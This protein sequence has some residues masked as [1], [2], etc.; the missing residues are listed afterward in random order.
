M[1]EKD[2]ILIVDDDDGMRRSL[3]LVLTKKGY[4]VETAE[5]GRE[6][7]G[8]AQ[9]RFFNAVLLDI[10]M[11]DVA[12]IDLLAPL[13]GMHPDIVTIMITGYASLETAMQALNGG[14][15]AYITKPLNMDEVVAK[16]R[17]TL[18][19]QRLMME[20]RKLLRELKQ[21]LTERML[22]D[23]ALE[24]AKEELEMR[25]AERT[26]ELKALNDELINEV[27]VRKQAEETQT[28][29]RQRLEA[30]WTIA[31]MTDADY[32]TLCEHVLVE[33]VSLTQ[34]PY[35]FFGFLNESE[36]IMTFH[37][38]SKEVLKDCRVREAPIEFPV[39]TAG[40]WA[41][42]VRHRQMM[43]INDYK[44]DHP[45]K[46]GLPEGHVPITRILEVPIFSGGHIIALSVVANKATDYTEEDA[47]QISAFVNNVQIILERKRAEEARQVT[48]QNFRNSLDNSPLGIRIVSSGGELL[49]ANQALLDIYGYNSIEELKAQPAGKLY[50][51]QSYAE[52]KERGKREKLG[53]PVPTRYEIS[54]VR[55]DGEVRHLEV[56]GKEVA[57][58]G[59]TQFQVLYQD[60]TERKRV[61][62][63]LRALS[64]RLVEMQEDERRAIA[65]E[66]HDQIGQSVS[67]LKLLLDKATHSPLEP[68]GP[69]LDEAKKLVNE[70][71]ASVRNMALDLRPSMLDDL[72][73]V[74]AL[75]W[76]FERYQTQANLHVNFKH[77]ELQNRF[78]PEINTAAYRITQEALTNVVRHA[79]VNEATVRVWADASTLLL[80]IEDKG[81]GFNV[82]AL[83]GGTSTG[84]RGMRERVHLL[85]GKL[86]VE[87]AVGA[88]TTLTVELPL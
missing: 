12:G 34:S 3:A 83:A 22:A 23:E 36:S 57:W 18:E 28:C 66:L 85:S 14:A 10:R 40:I 65:R 9:G 72:G 43:I 31:S 48:E 44:A 79:G 50:P 1:D 81:K 13:K 53:K 29:L 45:D 15:S 71:A 26:A 77:A 8:K 7:L 21:E 51:P 33:L 25:V 58:D 49:Y 27:R 32:Q 55:K 17:Y 19:K 73:L 11:P 67:F 5:T 56:Y 59:E 87:S 62:E 20:N 86:T 63:Q 6:A 84:L 74:P 47:R 30:L 37:S 46:K 80:H 39:A 61:E 76:L 70:L 41:N 42:A 75:L 35:A 88:G 68:A 78:A 69:S 16:V 2:S 24:R 52:H 4:E 64:H 60:I 54:I 38:W 82:G